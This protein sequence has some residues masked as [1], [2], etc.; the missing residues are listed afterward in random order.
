MVCERL[1]SCY[2]CDLI[3][4]PWMPVEAELI[5]TSKHETENP[6]TKHDKKNM[7]HAF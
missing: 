3:N 2:L 6:T 5:E 4:F 1:D 7:F